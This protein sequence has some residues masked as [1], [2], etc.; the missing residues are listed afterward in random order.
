M[1]LLLPELRGAVRDATAPLLGPPDHV[2]LAA[3][4]EHQAAYE[5]ALAGPPRG[6]SAG[7]C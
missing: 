1:D 3:C 5:V 4:R 2:A 7:P 6:C